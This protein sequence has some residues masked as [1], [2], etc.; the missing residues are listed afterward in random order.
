MGSHRILLMVLSDTDIS[1]VHVAESSH[2]GA[3]K[4]TLSVPGRARAGGL[5]E[6]LAHP[7]ECNNHRLENSW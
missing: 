6:T 7:S 5:H 4:G 1:A 3:S 2:E